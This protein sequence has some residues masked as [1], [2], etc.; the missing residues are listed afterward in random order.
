MKALRAWFLSR[1]LREKALLLALVVLAVAIWGTSFLGRARAWGQAYAQ[2]GEELQEQRFWLGR[3][4]AI[5]AAARQAIAQLDPA[6]TL[7]GTRLNAEIN[8]LAGVAGLTNT[9]VEDLRNDATSQFTV[10][11]LRFT[12]RK[13]SYT[14]LVRCYQELQK[15]SPY[16]GIEQFSLQSERADPN[17]LTATIKITSVEVNR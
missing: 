8:R 10:H 13:A 16:I 9:Q 12:V 4:P 6:Q 14:T 5:E 7:N 3:R 17:Q 1:V 11:S 15:R 2:T